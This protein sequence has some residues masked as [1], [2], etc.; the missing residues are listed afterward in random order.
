MFAALFAPVI[1]PVVAALVP[2]DTLHG[3]TEALNDG[4]NPDWDG[5]IDG[6]CLYEQARDTAVQDLIDARMEAAF[7]QMTHYL[8]YECGG[9]GTGY[10]NG[11]FSAGVPAEPEPW[12]PTRYVTYGSAP[13]NG[14]IGPV[15]QPRYYSV[16][17]VGVD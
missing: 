13:R 16:G 11:V 14:S 1:A 9:V 12:D 10:L 15:F 4:I 17:V 3:F 7:R 2:V 6:V 5:M 8:D